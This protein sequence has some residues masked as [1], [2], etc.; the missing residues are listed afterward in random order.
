MK[1]DS[2]AL[3]GM[4]AFEEHGMPWTKCVGKYRLIRKETIAVLG[5][6][7]HWLIELEDGATTHIPESCV[8]VLPNGSLQGGE[9]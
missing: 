8:A 5:P 3:F 7:P 4:I 2:D 1:A 9:Q 6:E